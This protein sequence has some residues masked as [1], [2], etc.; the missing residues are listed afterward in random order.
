MKIETWEY[1]ERQFK[2][3][4]SA[5]GVTAS[6]FDAAFANLNVPNDYR[7]FV[8]RYGGGIIGTYP[9]YGLRLAKSMGMVGR[10]RTA[11]EINQLFLERNWPG[12][13]NW[14]IFTIDQSGNPI[15]FA[16]DHSVW[17]SDIAPRQI[18]KLGS[19]FEDF[20]L[21]WCLRVKDVTNFD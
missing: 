5:E 9:I 14:F 8:V 12:V 16:S 10:K 3:S 17:I 1:V 19:D 20:V 11:P 6:E 7:E 13:E 4:Y 18:Q 21:K 2:S 15:G